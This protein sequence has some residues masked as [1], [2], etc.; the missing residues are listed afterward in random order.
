MRAKR[1]S[2]TQ[3][4]LSHFI[5]GEYIL[6]TKKKEKKGKTCVCV[7]RKEALADTNENVKRERFVEKYR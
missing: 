3:H 1:T 2:T 5:T 6:S 4:I 7:L